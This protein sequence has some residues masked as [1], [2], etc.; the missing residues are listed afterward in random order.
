MR[1]LPACT[2]EWYVSDTVLLVQLIDLD[3]KTE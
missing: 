3:P 2:A 1:L